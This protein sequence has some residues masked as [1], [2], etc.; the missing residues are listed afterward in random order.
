MLHPYCIREWNKLDAEI[1]NQTLG[2]K[3]KARI[4]RFIK[5]DKCSFN[6]HD[7][8]PAADALLFCNIG[9]NFY[10]GIYFNEK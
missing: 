7:P 2:G 4:I 9:T 5:V 6:I 3:F 1:K 8:A 10:S